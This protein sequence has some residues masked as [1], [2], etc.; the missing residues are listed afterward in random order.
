MKRMRRLVRWATRLYPRRW[1][2]RYGAE[3]DALLDDLDLRWRDLASVLQAAVAM[4]LKSPEPAARSGCSGSAGEGKMKRR[5]IVVVGVTLVVLAAVAGV[6]GAITG[7]N[8]FAQWVLEQNSRVSVD[9]ERH[10]ALGACQR[11][12]L[13]MIKTRIGDS[14]NAELR[15]VYDADTVM[16]SLDPSIDRREDDWHDVAAVLDLLDGGPLMPLGRVRLECSVQGS[17]PDARSYNA[18]SAEIRPSA[19]QPA[20]QAASG[21]SAKS[22]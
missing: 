7:I 15:A 16:W 13:W 11:E 10:L 3:L 20:N 14:G 18:R 1:R 17:G 4:R 22:D 6:G 12:L 5:R 19:D 21:A 9:V 2:R 8:W